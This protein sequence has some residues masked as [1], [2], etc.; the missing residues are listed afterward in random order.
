MVRLLL[1]PLDDYVAALR[2]FAAGW[3]WLRLAVLVA[4]VVLSWWLYVPLHELAHAFGCLLGGGSVSRLDLDPLYGAALLQRFFP[5]INVGSDYAGQL[6]GFD[7]GGSDATSLPTAFLPFIATI[8][9]GV[10]PLHAA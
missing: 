7:T 5:Y 2:R 1:Q 4:A 10:P 8:L 6:A 9:L 3:T